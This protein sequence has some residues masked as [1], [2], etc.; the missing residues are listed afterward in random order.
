MGAGKL[1]WVADGVKQERRQC[2]F[3]N[4]ARCRF[5]YCPALLT[6]ISVGASC[7]L[8]QPRS[9]AR[10]M[11]QRQPGSG[12]VPREFPVR[13]R[14]A[15]AGDALPGT[16][17]HGAA[18]HFK[19]STGHRQPASS[20]PASLAACFS[21]SPS[22]EMER[23]LQNEGRARLAVPTRRDAGAGLPSLHP[24]GRED[25]TASVSVV[26]FPFIAAA[27][28]MSQPFSGATEKGTG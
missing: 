19:A 12:S 1:G 24:C 16:N 7:Q 15:G 20:Q 17:G 18:P 6:K 21:P 9:A 23:Y 10:Q 13:E 22:S 14:R 25:V 11:N 5:H 8:P 27:G 2:L 4:M 28:R 3:A 26:A